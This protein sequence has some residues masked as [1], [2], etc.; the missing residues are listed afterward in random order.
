[1]MRQSTE[2]AVGGSATM[3]AVV[4][5]KP[6]N[7]SVQQIAVPAPGPG[8]V[9]VRL[10]RSGVCGTDIHL[11]HG[12]FS[13]KYPLVPGH[14][15]AGVVEAVGENVQS[16]A[17]GDQVA[18]NNRL[19]CG[20]C[21]QCRRAMPM[22]CTNLID[23]G[24]TAQGG[25][26]EYVVVPATRCHSGKGLTLDQ[27]V[28]A[29]PMACV[30][31][32]ID[33]LGVVPGANVLVFGAGTTGLLLA[34]ALQ[35]SGAASVT[36]AAPTAS[37][38]DLAS[39]L[40]IDHVVQIYRHD[41]AAGDQELKALAPDGFDIV[42]DATGSPNVIARTIDLTRSGGTIFLYGMASENA[43]I[44]LRPFEVFSRQL[45]IKGSFTQAFSMERGLAML[46]SGRVRVDQL[47]THRFELSDYADA[48]EA[49]RN[50]RSCIKAVIAQGD[51]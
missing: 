7:F 24:V 50:D 43:Q 27:L 28:F 20:E 29:E 46:S 37:K 26:A 32:G 19:D 49:V 36:V 35:A 38:L 9:R 16:L 30:M 34:Q 3:S 41:P 40:G 10:R 18:I 12:E 8:Q 23:H 13:P 14:E 1:M 39:N 45:T 21:A 42:V 11:H 44:T 15:M 48:L 31:H 2:G 4:Y 51:N 5:D 33:V 47:L 17:P 6:E 22:Y 25:F